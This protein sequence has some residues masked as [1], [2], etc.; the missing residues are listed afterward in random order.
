MA[1]F[2]GLWD[3]ITQALGTDKT[4][5]IAE[6]VGIEPPSVSAWKKQA[7]PPSTENLLKIA[8]LGNTS[9]EWL[10][11]GEGPA[12]ST[13]AFSF[14][15]RKALRI[16][17]RM[18]DDEGVTVEELAGDLILDA[19]ANRASEMFGNLRLLSED[20]R[21]LLILLSD[22]VKDGEHNE[23]RSKTRESIK[24]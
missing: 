15:E 16:I 5:S 8:R 10:L 24:H 22:L 6:L 3:R 12:P 23:A 4:G 7:K 1:K 9:V 20:E 21:Q 2:P 13:E 19:L 18:A 11:T 14:L 17:E